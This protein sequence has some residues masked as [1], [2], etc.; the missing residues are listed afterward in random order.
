MGGKDHNAVAVAAQAGFHFGTDHP[1]GDFSPDFG[2][3]DGE[4]FSTR[5]EGGAHGGY[6]HLLAGRHVGGPADDGQWCAAA[7]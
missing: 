3:F 6:D 5:V 4:G 7:H 2:F 1:L